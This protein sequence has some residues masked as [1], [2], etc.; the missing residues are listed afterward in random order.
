MTRE[1]EFEG[2]VLCHAIRNIFDRR[3]TA[4]PADEPVALPDEFVADPTK[5]KQWTRFL[6]KSGLPQV[7]LN[8]VAVTIEIL[9]APPTLAAAKGR[10]FR[11]KWPPAGP[12]RD[13]K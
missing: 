8:E 4:I 6:A 9:L 1:F 5:Q 13:T 11:G 10:V 2:A 7:T 3:K 12:W